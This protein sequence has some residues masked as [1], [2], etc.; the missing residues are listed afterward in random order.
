MKTILT[1][2]ALLSTSQVFAADCK[3]NVNFY[4]RAIVPTGV[5]SCGT[6]NQ[7]PLKAST[8]IDMM[9]ALASE[10]GYKV[11]RQDS[12]S[13]SLPSVEIGYGWIDYEGSGPMITESLC[14]ASV[15]DES[16]K[17]TKIQESA[18]ALN[19]V[20]AYKKC[21]NKVFGKALYLLPSCN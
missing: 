18:R 20:R 16:G 13:N 8:A 11:V 19:P 4:P 1:I 17:K 6:I 5:N 2:L 7:T 10:S 12:R 15:V 21:L 3:I 14:F 9:S